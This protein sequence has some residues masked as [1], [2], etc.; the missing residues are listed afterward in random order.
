MCYPNEFE[1]DLEK[2]YKPQGGWI[3]SSSCPV[4]TSM[5]EAVNGNVISTAM[6]R[7]LD[8]RSAVAK[9][10][11]NE[12][13]TGKVALHK[14]ASPKVLAGIGAGTLLGFVIVSMF[15]GRSG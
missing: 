13:K 3:C 12:T 7:G 5:L 14:K 4:E 15:N 9:R 1:T 2:P 10:V 11:A 6:K 8:F